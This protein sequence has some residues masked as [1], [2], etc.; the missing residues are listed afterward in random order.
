VQT[1]PV[2]E[3]FAT[4]CKNALATETPRGTIYQ[5]M[6]QLMA[7]P[8]AL[9]SQVPA[10]T[11]SDVE[12]S[13]AGWRLGGEHI[14]CRQEDLTIM[15]L[16]T[17]PGVLQPPHDHGMNAF[18]GVFEGC[19]EQRFWRRTSTGVQPAAGQEL[20]AGDMI[21]LGVRA[22]HAISSP[23]SETARAV[24]VYLGDIYDIDRSV[25]D[26]DTLVEHPMTSERYDEFCQ[27]LPQQGDLGPTLPTQLHDFAAACERAAT[28]PDAADRITE[29]L[30][31][32]VAKPTVLA[33]A[34]PRVANPHMTEAGLE[35]GAG[36]NILT[37]DHVRVQL[38]ETYDGV[39]QPPHDHGQPAWVGVFEGCEHHR[40]FDRDGQLI[41]A[42]G[43]QSLE[44]GDVLAMGSTDVHAIGAP[45][46]R[47]ARAIHV[48]LGQ[49]GASGVTLFNPDTLKGGPGGVDRYLANCSP[50]N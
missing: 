36:Y 29:L 10:F 32:L 24:H 22:I 3:D 6:Q 13:P 26:P 31:E 48:Y 34:T 17:L 1:P 46:G 42:A 41:T 47:P 50:V 8:V 16:D 14:V 20:G 45:S 2:L 7:D 33:A 18:I 43:E 37:S 44:P 28:G 39:V 21:A 12:V 49:V 19:E 25:F 30:T 40:F 5:L 27:P 11:A 23:S 15:V 4:A 9:A 38:M 35:V